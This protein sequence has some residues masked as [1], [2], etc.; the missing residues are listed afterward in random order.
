MIAAPGGWLVGAIERTNLG[1]R[2]W[3]PSTS[4]TSIFPF[5]T[6]F[7][8][9]AVE[10]IPPIQSDAMLLQPFSDG[11][12]EGKEEMPIMNVSWRSPRPSFFDLMESDSSKENRSPDAFSIHNP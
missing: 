8:V 3:I 10:P 6:V 11:E 1:H 2:N 5:C 12:E 7:Q 4:P 9:F